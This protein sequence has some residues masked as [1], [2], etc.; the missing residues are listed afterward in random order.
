MYGKNFK[1]WTISNQ[2]PT[3]Y[4][5]INMEKAQRLDGSGFEIY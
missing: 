3:F 1:D 4:S 2:A 5:R